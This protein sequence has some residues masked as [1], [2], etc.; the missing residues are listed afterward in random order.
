MYPGKLKLFCT[1]HALVR[2]MHLPLQEENNEA[3]GAACLDPPINLLGKL[4]LAENKE[5]QRGRQETT[6]GAGLKRI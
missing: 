5:R 6:M 3:L 1:T 2:S 4:Q